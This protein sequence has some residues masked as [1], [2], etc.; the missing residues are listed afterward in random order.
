MTASL[1]SQMGG[2][3][4]SDGSPNSALY[5]IPDAIAYFN[6]PNNVAYCQDELR[7]VSACTVNPLSLQL[8]SCSCPIPGSRMSQTDPAAINFDFNNKNRGRQSGREDRLRL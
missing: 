4:N 8:T 1:A 7:F 6:D 5:S 3:A 2:I